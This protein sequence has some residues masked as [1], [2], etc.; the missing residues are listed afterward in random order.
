MSDPALLLAI[1]RRWLEQGQIAEAD[2]QILTAQ[3]GAEAQQAIRLGITDTTL[4]AC[5]DRRLLQLQGIYPLLQAF[6]RQQLGWSDCPIDLLWNLWLPLAEQLIQWRAELDRPL[7]Q[8]I[9]GMQGTGK[10][11]LTQILTEILR[12][13]GFTVCSFSIDDLYLSYQERQQLQQEDPRFRWRGPPGT[14]DVA[15]GLQVLQQFRQADFPVVLPRFDKSLHQG[16]G[17]RVAPIAIPE[18]DIVLFEGWFVGVRPI[19]DATFTTAPPPI[20]TEPDRDF[21]I[22]INQRLYD[23]LP[24]WEQLDRLI[25]LIPTDYRL[26]QQWRQ[27]AEQRLIDRHRSGMS[28]TEVQA[29]VEYFW[30][31]LHP[32]LFLPP[33]LASAAVDLVIR[34]NANHRPEGGV[35]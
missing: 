22:A 33:L 13:G 2:R 9:L 12:Q 16:A 28:A 5:L 35:G 10:T 18:A 19:P 21:A 3:I 29:F 30:Q 4:E 27:E 15:L 25:A 6:C 8:G 26:S 7:I 34:I 1:L 11:T 14:H 32:E 31:S 23:Y 20:I 17:D 24:L